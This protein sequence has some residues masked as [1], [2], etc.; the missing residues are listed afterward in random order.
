MIGPF[1]T[2]AVE[3]TLVAVLALID[4]AA[5]V[6][7]ARRS[8]KAGALGCLAFASGLFV[9]ACSFFFVAG[10]AKGIVDVRVYAMQ[11]GVDPANLVDDSTDSVDVTIPLTALGVLLVGSV[12]W[13]IGWR[14]IRAAAEVER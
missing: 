4:L 3:Y 7:T 5:I 2:E 11:K 6:V 13:P 10:E 8:P 12:T 14:R 9:L 1:R